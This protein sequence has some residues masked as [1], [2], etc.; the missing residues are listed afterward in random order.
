MSLKKSVYLLGGFVQGLYESCESEDEFNSEIESNDILKNFMYKWLIWVDFMDISKPLLTIH[1]LPFSKTEL[2]Y[3]QSPFLDAIGHIFPMSIEN[4]FPRTFD[5]LKY[6]FD[7]V[8]K[9]LIEWILDH[10]KISTLD[11]EDIFRHLCKLGNLDMIKW[12][13]TKTPNINVFND[14]SISVYFVYASL[15]GKLDVFQWLYSEFG[16]HEHFEWDTECYYTCLY[17]ACDTNATNIVEWLIVT[18]NIKEIK[19]Q[20]FHYSP[21]DIACN[22]GYIDIAKLLYAHYGDLIFQQASAKY[23]R[24]S[25][26]NKQVIEWLQ[27]NVNSVARTFITEI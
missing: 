2:N 7:K 15:S 21:F 26:N 8:D 23:I 11:Y 22:K 13:R 3:V 19:L 16:L 17:N 20:M 10:M 18:F 27:N 14:K 4:R 1:P 6:A 25:K 5:A 24:N 9:Q 12:V